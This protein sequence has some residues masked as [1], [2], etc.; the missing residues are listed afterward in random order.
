MNAIGIRIIFVYLFMATVLLGTQ[1][2]KE[3]DLALKYQEWLKLTQYIILPQERDVFMALSNDRD[4]DIF[5]EA[6]WK[7]RDP[8]PGTPQNEYKEEHIERFRY[9][10][11]YFR[12]GTSRE[13]WMTDMG[14]MYI[15]LGKPVSIERFE[16]M[17]GI[18]P[19]QVWY[20]YGDKN[21]GLPTHFNLVFF[22]R[23]GSGEFKL[24]NSL[25]DGPASLII[26]KKGLSLTNHQQLYKKIRTLA[27]TLAG[28]SISMIPGQYSIGFRP[29]LRDNLIMEN[30]VESPKMDIS[31]SYATHFLNY[32]GVVNTEY[33]TNYVESDAGI[34]IIQDSVLNINFVHFSISPSKVS[35]DYF[36]PKDQYFCNFQLNVSVRKEENIIFQYSKDYPF[37]FPPENVERVRGSGIAIQDSFPMIEGEYKLNVLIQNSVGKEFS[38]FEHDFVILEHPDIPRL[39]AP[40]LGYGLQ[41]YPS[42][43]NV[44]F[45]SLDKKLLVDSRNTFSAKEEVAILFNIT[46]VTRELWEN[47][48]IEVLIKS[49]GRKEL[50]E[51][52]YILDLRNFPFH[53][54]MGIAYSFPASELTSDYFEMK[55][56]LKDSHSTI[57][58]EKTSRFIVSPREIVPHPTTLV[59]AFPLS[60]SFLYFYSLAYQY[61]KVNRPEKAEAFYNRAYTLK[62]N[63]RQGLVAY[64]QFLLKMKKFSQSISLIETIK[65]NNVEFKFQYYLIKGKALMGM[66]NYSDAILNLVEGNKIY[67]SNTNLLNSLGFCYYKTGEKKKSLDV[68]KASLRLNPDQ[69]EIK[70]LVEEIEKN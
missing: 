59:K 26:D 10:N 60:N 3:R 48:K 25:A 55:L 6:F 35:I 24:Y 70:K 39:T 53:E 50:R 11:E 64:A 69:A 63:Y 62:P 17:S 15:I 68:L 43:L 22:Q 61:E 7:Q 67:D 36:R 14:R 66:E 8:T 13:G 37:Y 44:P 58:D 4:R 56:I 30:I 2:I 16:G 29:S 65:D 40:V 41:D 32:K 1:K 46:K 23:S 49:V 12:R 9:A 54:N 27:P 52:S 42:H 38:V 5:I 47:G 20:Y 31:S 33:L 57:M 21:K 28:P 45:K 51:K 34:A 18:Y 19:C